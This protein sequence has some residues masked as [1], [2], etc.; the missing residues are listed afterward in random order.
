MN[1]VERQQGK[2]EGGT[3]EHDGLSALLGEAGFEEQVHRGEGCE[4]D[5]G[6]VDD[7]RSKRFEEVKKEHDDIEARDYKLSGKPVEN[8]V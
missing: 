1:G 7:I 8:A 3:D 4:M 6:L 2:A 5:D